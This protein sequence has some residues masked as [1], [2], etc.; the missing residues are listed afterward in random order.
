MAAAAILDFQNL[1]FVTFGTVKRVELRNRATFCRNRCNRG[2][3]IAIFP[4]F[5]MVAAAI[6][7]FKNF[8]FLTVVTVKKVELHQCV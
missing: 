3:D 2:R 7:D 1:K 5:K 4:F 8:K 6:L